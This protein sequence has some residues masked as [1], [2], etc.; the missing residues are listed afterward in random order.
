MFDTYPDGTRV[1][2]EG[3]GG[4]STDTLAVDGVPEG[5]RTVSGN[6]R[7]ARIRLH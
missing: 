6:Y 2:L 4:G 5:C 3:A 1:V 7:T